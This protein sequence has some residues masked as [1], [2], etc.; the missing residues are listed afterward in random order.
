MA[1]ANRS[2]GR[3]WAGRGGDRHHT[4]AAMMPML[5]MA[6]SQNGMAMP[7]AAMISPP[8]AGP[9]A[10]LMLMPTLLAAT[11]GGR[12]CRGTRPGTMACHAG[13]VSAAAAPAGR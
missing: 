5:L 4:S 1:P 10:R 2:A 8:S 9:T 12:L 11:A 6:L 7:D 13:A 3:R